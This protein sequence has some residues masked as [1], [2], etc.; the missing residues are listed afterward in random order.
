MKRVTLF[1]ESCHQE[2]PN[3]MRSHPHPCLPPGRT[4]WLRLGTP[5]VLSLEL[6]SVGRAGP[7]QTPRNFHPRTRLPHRRSHADLSCEVCTSLLLLN[8]SRGATI[9]PGEL[10]SL[11]LR[12]TPSSITAMMVPLPSLNLQAASTCA[13]WLTTW[14]PMRVRFRCH[15]CVERF[16]GPPTTEE[17]LG[18]AQLHFLLGK[19]TCCYGKGLLTSSFR[20][21]EEVGVARVLQRSAFKAVALDALHTSA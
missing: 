11:C 8:T 19:N 18:M 21:L 14:R 9:L 16:T 13:C 5:T 1:L 7:R 4:R 12:S 10:N 17:G 2:D 20:R 15:C 6:A 3:C